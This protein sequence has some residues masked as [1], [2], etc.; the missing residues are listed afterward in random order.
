MTAKTPEEL[1]TEVSDWWTTGIIDIHPG[2][3]AMRGYPN[4]RRRADALPRQAPAPGSQHARR[5]VAIRD[6]PA[7][8][9]ARLAR[10]PAAS[11]SRDPGKGLRAGGE[12]PPGAGADRCAYGYFLKGG[13]RRAV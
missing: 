7:V 3:I 1:L 10:G 9:E 6:L 13:G 2:K 5:R 4:R 8:R 12:R 11:V